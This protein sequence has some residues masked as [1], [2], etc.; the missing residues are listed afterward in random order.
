M[1]K[2]KT[3]HNLT[4]LCEISGSHSLSMKMRVLWDTPCSL[5]VDWHFRYPVILNFFSSRS[6]HLSSSHA[7]SFYP[8]PV[9]SIFLPLMLLDS[10][11]LSLPVL[12]IPCP[13]VALIRAI[14]YLSL[15]FL[16]H[17]HQPLAHFITLV[18]CL[19]AT[20][21]LLV[22]LRLQLTWPNPTS[23]AELPCTAYSSSWWWKQ[24]APLN[25]WSTPMRL[26][27]TISQKTLIF[28]TELP[29]HY[30]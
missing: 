23:P 29:P 21:S 24:Y 22:Q 10:I 30:K 1:S 6:L 26:H 18:P 25:C 5:G 19:I 7:S 28:M 9:P 4:Q 14:C 20:F 15:S 13:P 27:G 8:Q 12:A 2:M 16:S 17:P 11:T 3:N